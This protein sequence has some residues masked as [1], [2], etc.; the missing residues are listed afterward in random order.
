MACAPKSNASAV[1]IW[2]AAKDVRDGRT[3]PVPK[4]LRDAHY[5]AAKTLGQARAI[6]IRTTSPEDAS[7]RSTSGWT[8]PITG[9]PIGVSRNSSAGGSNR[10]QA[11][12]HASRGVKCPM[13]KTADPLAATEMTRTMV[14]PA[15]PHADD[16]AAPTKVGVRAAM[17]AMLAAIEPRGAPCRLQRCLPAARRPR[18]FESASVVMLYMPMSTEV[19]TTSAAIRCFQTGK[20]VCV[21]KVIWDRQDMHAVEVHSIDDRYMEIDEHGIRTPRGGRLAVPQSI[22]LVVVPGLAFDAC[23]NRLGRGSGFYDRFLSRLRRSAA[24]AGLAFDAQ[25]IDKVPVDERDVRVNRVVTDRRV[26]VSR[27]SRMRH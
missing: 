23:G 1:A 10:E 24:A 22:D 19:D 13:M 17:R 12:I 20:I 25:I 21:P 2:S 6:G 16:G 4:H 15:N 8:A 9:P 5:A 3:L 27:G 7:S 18:R 11:A 26:T 14:D